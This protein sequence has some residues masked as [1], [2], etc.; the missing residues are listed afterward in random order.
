VRV[1]VTYVTMAFRQGSRWTHL[2]TAIAKFLSTPV[3]EG[4]S[5]TEE[6]PAWMRDG[7]KAVLLEGAVTLRLSASRSIRTTYGGWPAPAQASRYAWRSQPSWHPRTTIPT[8]EM[9]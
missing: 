6:R 1:P 4:T 8:T 7:A 9:R 2:A 3:Q 5:R